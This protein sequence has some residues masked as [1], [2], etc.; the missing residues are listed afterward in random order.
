MPRS[1]AIR[2]LLLNHTYH[3]RGQ[4]TTYLRATGERV[5]VAAVVEHRD[6]DPVRRIF[7]GWI[8]GRIAFGI[9][10]DLRHCPRRPG[11]DELASGDHL[12]EQ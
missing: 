2:A 1:A 7:E 8:R 9:G 5:A 10:E 12:I 3:H 11:R 6:A 4:L